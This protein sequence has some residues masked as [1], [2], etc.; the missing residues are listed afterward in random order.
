MEQNVITLNKEQGDVG[1]RY[2]IRRLI[3]EI[4][5]DLSSIYQLLEKTYFSP[6]FLYNYSSEMGLL[7]GQKILVEFGM[8]LTQYVES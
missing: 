5:E 1:A 6:S 7:E 8:K 4:E 2:S 3:K